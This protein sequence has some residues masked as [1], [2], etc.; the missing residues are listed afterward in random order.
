[1]SNSH[2]QLINLEMS[3][4]EYRIIV[5]VF[6]RQYICILYNKKKMFFI[7]KKDALQHFFDDGP[8]D[9]QKGVLIS[10]TYVYKNSAD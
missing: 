3:N 1:M 6:C 4:F 10:Q 9:L 8:L 2:W 7:F 5:V